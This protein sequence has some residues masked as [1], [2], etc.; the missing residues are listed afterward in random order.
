VPNVDH[1]LTP[2]FDAEIDADPVA[3]ATETV[4]DNGYV[5][6]SSEYSHHLVAWA[7]FENGGGLQTTTHNGN[8]NQRVQS[9]VQT[10]GSIN[11]GTEAW[12]GR[13][14]IVVVLDETIDD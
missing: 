8:E 6:I 14:I 9:Y 13:E 4:S 2:R 5:T 3:V 7:P 10:E 1:D 12:S 11:I